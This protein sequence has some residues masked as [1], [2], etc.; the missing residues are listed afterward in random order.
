M[1]PNL[2]ESVQKDHT[3]SCP[4]ASENQRSDNLNSNSNPSSADN[5]FRESKAAEQD[6]VLGQQSSPINSSD[7]G[8]TDK[9]SIAN[10]SAEPLKTDNKPVMPETTGK[11]VNSISNSAN[12]GT[13]KSNFDYLDNKARNPRS[14]LGAGVRGYKS[15]HFVGEKI[16]NAATKITRK[17]NLKGDEK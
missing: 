17:H 15:G 11:K 10:A 3:R 9:D 12:N 16:G 14:V 2:S 4:T 5:P 1:L 6:N 7:E 8:N 13:P